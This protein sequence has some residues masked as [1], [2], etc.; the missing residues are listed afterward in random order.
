MSLAMPDQPPRTLPYADAA[1]P[2]APRVRSIVGRWIWWLCYG[3][4]AVAIV[5][6]FVA[7]DAWWIRGGVAGI[8]LI[9]AIRIVR[10]ERELR[11]KFRGH[12]RV[13]GY[14]IYVDDE[15]CPKC[16][17]GTKDLPDAAKR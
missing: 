10:A 12:C 14:D 13:C 15:D 3:V 5:T 17:V 11:E 9:G 16:G 7:A 1:T 2:R 6:M 8:A 4:V